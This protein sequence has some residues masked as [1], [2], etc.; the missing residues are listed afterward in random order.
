[1]IFI[2]AF[3]KAYLS[4]EYTPF[5]YNLASKGV[6]T[7]VKTIFAFRGIET[8]MFTGVWPNV[9]GSWTEFKLSKDFRQTRKF[10]ILSGIFKIL[11]ILPYDGLIAKSRF[12]VERYLFRRIYKTP[13]VIPS[14]ALPYFESTQIKETHEEGSLE[15]ITTIF[16]VFRKKDIPYVCIEPWIRGDKGVFSKAKKIIRKKGRNFWYIKF[17]HLDHLG[18]KFGPE[19]SFFKDELGK[20]DN[21]VKDIVNLA[22]M[23]KGN[24][25]ILIIADHGMS[26]VHSKVNIIDELHRL[27]SQMYKDYVVFVDSTIIRFWFFNESAIEEVSHMLNS[28]KCGHM[29]SAEEKQQ[30]NIPTNPQFGELIF[31][32]D[33]GFVTQPS[34][35]S[36]KSE[37]KGMHGYAYSKTPES[38]PILIMKGIKTGEISA[39][40]EI[41]YVD[42][43]HF[44]LRSLLPETNEEHEELSG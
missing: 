1:M 27:H 8:T 25:S 3:S 35:F 29:L 39:K 34:F 41:N 2:D 24:L 33:E 28:L 43:S 30:L 23:K 21:Y 4:E 6:S 40:H 15:G 10:R 37:V 17:S 5:L 9:H 26:W 16:D 36:K 44:I 14:E 19:P 38:H 31:V 7:T 13:N 20:I 11:D 42:I 12:F 22:K 32:L 18:H